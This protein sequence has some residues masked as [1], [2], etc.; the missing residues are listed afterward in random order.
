MNLSRHI[1]IILLLTATLLALSC[2]SKPEDKKV[3]ASVNDAQILLSELQKEV[4]GSAKQHPES[5]LSPQDVEDRLK[6]MIERKLMVQEAVRLGLS[7]DERFV[8]TIKAYWEQTLIRELIDAKNREWADRL[9]V[10]DDEIRQEYKR[11]QYRAV[12]RAARADSKELAEDYRDRMQKGLRVAGEET[13]GPCFYDDV[14]QSPLRHA[15]DMETGETRVFDQDG[16]FIVVSVVKKEKTALPPL[17]AMQDRIKA[18]LLEQKRQ[19][20]LA[21]WVE[22]LKRSSKIQINRSMLTDADHAR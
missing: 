19:K 21:D 13:V 20:A 1:T 10:T 2:S 4:A 3:V 16:A 7:E 8:Q 14:R 18:S 12:I 5:R 9:Y 11:S 22:T 6:T 15:F 17:A